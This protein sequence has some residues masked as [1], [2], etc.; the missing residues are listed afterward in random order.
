M[1]QKIQHGDAPVRLAQ[2]AY[3]LC[4]LLGTR[5]VGELLAGSP[6]SLPGDVDG[7]GMASSPGASTLRTHA[8]FR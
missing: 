2:G 1:L 5:A 3:Q 8:L 4:Q 6:V 7:S